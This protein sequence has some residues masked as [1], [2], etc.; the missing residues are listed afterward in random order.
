MVKKFLFISLLFLLISNLFAE[1][2]DITKLK[3]GIYIGKNRIFIVYTK[4]RVTVK[5]GKITDVKIL[6]K[7]SSWKGEKAYKRIPNR[8][9]QK[10]SLDVDAVTGATISSQAVVD[11]VREKIKE[12]LLIIKSG[13]E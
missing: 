4:V 13:K 11:S 12:V 2:V 10:Q 3:D 8:I 6:K 7:F 1:D 5:Q 9:V